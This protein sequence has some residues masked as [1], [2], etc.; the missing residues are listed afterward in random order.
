MKKT[1]FTEQ[2]IAFALSRMSD[3]KKIALM[4]SVSPFPRKDS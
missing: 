1:K 4:F 2:Q 3:R